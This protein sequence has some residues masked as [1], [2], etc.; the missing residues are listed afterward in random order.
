MAHIVGNGLCAVI[1]QLF[2]AS[3]GNMCEYRQ[4]NAKIVASTVTHYSLLWQHD[5]TSFHAQWK[6]NSSVYQPSQQ[7][8]QRM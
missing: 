5:I 2:A 7:I 1:H 8:K 4:L 3:G 6:T